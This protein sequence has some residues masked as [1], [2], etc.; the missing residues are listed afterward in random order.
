[1]SSMCSYH[2]HQGAPLYLP[3]LKTMSGR[4]KHFVNHRLGCT[5]SEDSLIL[6]VGLVPA[7]Q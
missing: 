3:L 6:I 2:Q 7:S 1:M 4:S 5:W